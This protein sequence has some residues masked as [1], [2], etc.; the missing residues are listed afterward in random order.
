MR[1]F[2]KFLFASMFGTFLAFFLVFA[3]LFAVI[4]VIAS[5]AGA[6]KEVSIKDQSIL[7][8]NFEEEVTERTSKDPFENFDWNSFESTP[9]IGLNDILANLEK[10]AKDDRIKGI[11]LD[12]TFNDMG[13]AS[14][15][16][17]RDAL[18]DFKSSG[19]FI[20][21][22]SDAMDQNSYYLASVSDKIYL[23]PGGIMQMSGLS[24]QRMFFKG[25]LDKLEIE[26]EVI[27]HGKFK[28]A[29]EPFTRENMSE[30]NRLQTE[31]FVNSLWNTMVNEIASSRNISA[32]RINELCDGLTVRSP[33][34]AVNMGLADGVKYRDEVLAELR[35]KTEMEEDAKLR[36]VEMKKYA[37]VKVKS[38]EKDIEDYKNRIAV[39]YAGGEIQYG[40]SE[41]GVMGS[42]TIAEAIEKARKDEKVKAIVL[43]VNSPGGSSLASDIIW[44][45]VV[46][47]KAEKPVV[48][49]MGN[50]AASGGYYISCAADKIIADE[51][52]ITGSIGVFGLIP[53]MKGLFNNKLGITFDT[54][55]TNKYADMGTGT[56][57]MKPVE[58]Q[59][60]TNIVERIYDDFVGKVAEGRSMTY[61]EVDSIGQGR[62]WSGTDALN[63]GLVDEIGGL[64]RAVE[65]AVELAE[66]EN[67][68][69]YELPEQKNAIEELMKQF[70]ENMESKMAEKYFGSYYGEFNGAFKSL[71]EFGIYARMPYDL[72]IH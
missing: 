28:S 14:M 40:K 36:F 25:A 18:L 54:V 48:V 55:N 58:R 68:S 63:L 60:I 11:F 17:V 64:N 41:S 71:T 70:S 57:P 29:V 2:F 7:Y 31:K 19:K 10:A 13:M 69:I 35:E 37:D 22:F 32:D 59:Y 65:V 26:I 67:Y 23:H 52:T 5:S 34:D 72:H 1:Q 4:G 39:V 47:A 9:Q 16:E 42:E 50:L 61:A 15:N 3:V 12:L 33:E 38:E 43:R 49:S 21:T 62:V 8:I 46:L 66:L 44:R 20:Y 53:N 45:Q 56:R 24:A 51:N 6:E 27:R 30:A